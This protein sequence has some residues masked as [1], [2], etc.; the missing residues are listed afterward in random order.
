MNIKINVCCA[1]CRRAKPA[2]YKRDEVSC[3]HRPSFYALYAD[4]CE[5]WLPSKMDIRLYIQREN[6]KIKERE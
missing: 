1:S 3:K 4:P 2:H 6:D 5:D